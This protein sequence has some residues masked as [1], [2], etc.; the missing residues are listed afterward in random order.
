MNESFGKYSNIED[1]SC[2]RGGQRGVLK[3]YKIL[4]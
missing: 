2:G 4:D 1:F 3:T